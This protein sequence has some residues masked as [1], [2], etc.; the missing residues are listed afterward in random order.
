LQVISGVV[1]PAFR[2]LGKEKVSGLL[3]TGR[4]NKH[5]NKERTRKKQQQQEGT[6][7]GLKRKKGAERTIKGG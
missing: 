5:S 7:Y 1:A 2:R 3:K 6:H 4:G